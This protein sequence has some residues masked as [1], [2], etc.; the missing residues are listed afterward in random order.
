MTNVSDNLHRYKDS[1]NKRKQVY[2]TVTPELVPCH[3][4]NLFEES[5]QIEEEKKKQRRR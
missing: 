1:R 2:E 3:H 5:E 4:I